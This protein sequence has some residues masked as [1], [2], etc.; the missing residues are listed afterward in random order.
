LAG[1]EVELVSVQNRERRLKNALARHR[2]LTLSAAYAGGGAAWSG[3]ICRFIAA[4]TAAGW[5]GVRATVHGGETVTITFADAFGMKP[6]DTRVIFRGV[7][8]ATVM[9]VKLAPDGVHIQ[10]KL[11]ADSAEKRCL[12]SC[13]AERTFSC[14]VR[15]RAPAIRRRSRRCLQDPKM[16]W[17]Q[18]PASVLDAVIDEHA[19][20]DKMRAWGEYAAGVPHAVQG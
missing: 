20:A 8:A 7:K 13:A 1:A 4:P 15:S 16:S 5:P 11:K 9:D 12:R 17:S 14:A 3:W 6:D 10:T 2:E 18:D 19:F